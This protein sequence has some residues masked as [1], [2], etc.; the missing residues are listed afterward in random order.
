MYLPETPADRI[1]D[2]GRAGNGTIN[3]ETGL[4]GN[5]VKVL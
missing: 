5:A 3:F 4:S 1:E 2:L